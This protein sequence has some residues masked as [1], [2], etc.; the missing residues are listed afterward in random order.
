MESKNNF[1]V[2]KNFLKELLS[3]D[4]IKK[5]ITPYRLVLPS[6]SG[7]RRSFGGSLFRGSR[8]QESLRFG[9]KASS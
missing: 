6:T 1:G 7:N 8:K 3:L 2:I 4:G 9:K 5:L